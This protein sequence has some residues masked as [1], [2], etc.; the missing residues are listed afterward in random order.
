MRT[1]SCLAL[2]TVLLAAAAGATP[3]TP[4]HVSGD[5]ASP[6]PVERLEP[7]ELWRVTDG[8]EES[9]EILGEIRDAA[10]DAEGNTLL[11]DAS[12]NT[13]RMYDPE[14]VPLGTVGRDGEGPGEFQNPEN[15]LALP[16]GRV[17]V[18]QIMP[19]K[20]ITMDRSGDPGESINMP[21]S[22][23]MQ[24]LMM[25]ETTQNGFVVCTSS[26]SMGDD[27][28][29]SITRLRSLDIDGAPRTVFREQE[30]KMEVSGGGMAMRAGDG[31]DFSRFWSAGWDGRVY[32]SPQPD[33]YL[34]EVYAPDGTLERVIDVAYESVERT[35]EEI[36]AI[37]EQRSGMS[38]N[39]GSLD[40]GEVERYLRDVAV[41]Y[42]RPD[43]TLWVASS[44]GRRE[45]PQGAVGAFDVFDREG[46]FVGRV[47][48]AADFDPDYD[49]FVID[50]DRLYVFKEVLATPASTPGGGGGA[51]VIRLGEPRAPA[52]PDREPMPYEVVCYDLKG[53]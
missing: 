25:A 20:V 41:L 39:G 38:F 36:A 18:S 23:S 5:Y 10:V 16:D 22:E 27:T 37:E 48:V 51:M 33:A 3:P 35:A 9:G 24:V 12:F 34:I 17:G 26:M 13:V 31:D 21:G 45:R 14:G 30:R 32:V 40:M 6:P 44:R 43:G 19:G 11:L 47:A 8:D 1:V 53:L 52:D 46:G 49:R 29:T 7:R 28:M 42:P 4:P 50:G 15:C 2:A